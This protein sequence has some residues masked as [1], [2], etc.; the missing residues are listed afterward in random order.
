MV[1]RHFQDWRERRAVLRDLKRLQRADED[2]LAGTEV[3]PLHLAKAA[4]EAGD[5]VT[6]AARWEDA[7]ARLP[8]VIVESRDSLTILLALGRFDEAEALMRERRKRF[9]NDE[10]YLTGLALAAQGRKDHAGAALRWKA[11]RTRAPHEIEGYLMGASCLRELGQLEEAGELLRGAARVSP[12]DSRVWSEVMH[13]ARARG[14]TDAVLEA[15]SV[16]GERFNM[17][18]GYATQA[19]VLRELGRAEEAEALLERVLPGFTGDADIA[20]ARAEL[21]EHADDTERAIARWSV[22]R[23]LQPASPWGYVH[24]A[25][26]LSRAGRHAEADAVLREA[27]DRFPAE[28]WPLTEYAR[29]AGERGDQTEAE[30]RRAEAARRFPAP[31]EGS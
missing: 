12:D 7:R 2:R 31:P 14:D 24:G 22:V 15:C 10:H 11:V 27:I 29:I 23:R 9:V 6:A 30:E 13:L 19:R 21:A 26:R 4:A 1:W 18:G 20:S 25:R 5:L 28:P 17:A 3:S 16:L 8:E